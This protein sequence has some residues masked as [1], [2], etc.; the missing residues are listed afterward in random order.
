MI[1]RLL[2]YWQEKNCLVW[3][4]Y[5]VQVGAGTMNPATI[6]RVLGPEPWNVAYVEPSIRADDGRFGEN[7][8]RMQQ[9][10]QAFPG[11]RRIPPATQSA[12]NRHGSAAST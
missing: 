2:E 3:Q 12:Q 6:L 8:N 7:P 1:L 10:Y 4:P 9:H 5:N 11:R